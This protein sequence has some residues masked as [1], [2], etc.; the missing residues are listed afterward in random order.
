MLKLGTLCTSIIPAF[1]RLRRED[2]EFEASLGY[3]NERSSL[4][5]QRNNGAQDPQRKDMWCNQVELL[6]NKRDIT[7]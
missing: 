2:C 1:G 6:I 3:V 7:K 4:K 5:S